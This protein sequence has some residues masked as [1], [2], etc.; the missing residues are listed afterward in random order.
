MSKHIG[1][2]CQVYWKDDDEWYE[3]VVDEF[4]PD[5]GWHVQY[6]DGDDEWIANIDDGSLIRFDKV[7]ERNLDNTGN[8]LQSDNKEEELM[9]VE[10]KNDEEELLQDDE[11]GFEGKVDPELDVDKI[12]EGEDTLDDTMFQLPKNNTDEVLNDGEDDDEDAL[13]EEIGGE[14]FSNIPQ[15]QQLN[16]S[17]DIPRSTEEVKNSELYDDVNDIDLPNTTFDLPDRGIILM[18]TITSATNMPRQAENETDGRVFFRVLYVDGGS[19][20][21]MF[22]CKT[23]IFSSKQ[24]DDLSFPEWDNG[25]F[26]FEMV[27][28]DPSSKGNVDQLSTASSLRKVRGK[29]EPKVPKP[30]SFRVHGEILV[31]LYR[32]RAQGGSEFVGQAVFD[33]EDL[34]KSGTTHHSNAVGTQVRSTNGSFPVITRIGEVAGGGLCH[35]DVQLELAWKADGVDTDILMDKAGEEIIR[36][37]PLPIKGRTP[38]VPEGQQPSSQKKKP[39][40]LNAKRQILESHRIN[41]ENLMLAKRIKAHNIK[42]ANKH[43]SVAKAEDVYNKPPPDAGSQPKDAVEAAALQFSKK[44]NRMERQEL[45]AIY[46]DLKKDVF[47]REQEKKQTLANLSRLKL[48]TKKYGLAN[49]RMK[50]KIDSASAQQTVQ[51]SFSQVAESKNTEEEE[52][53]AVLKDKILSAAEEKESMRELR[54]IDETYINSVSDPEFREHLIEFSALQDARRALVNRADTA[55][56]QCATHQASL[57]DS[58]QREMV[59]RQRLG[60]AFS[61]LGNKYAGSADD[62]NRKSLT[63]QQKAMED[64]LQ[65]I[66]RVRNVQLE[67]ARTEAAYESGVHLGTLNDT[68]SELQGVEQKL[69][70]LIKKTE[71][72]LTDARTEKSITQEKLDMLSKERISSKLRDNL[73]MMNQILLD[74]CRHQ[75]IR[76][77]DSNADAIELES[78]RMTLKR[79]QSEAQ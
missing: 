76:L 28:P 14:E 47:N 26:R 3:G 39:K 29:I 45:L 40:T 21:T 66:E 44:I 73:G 36:L 31:A 65:S 67:L 18:G 19:K 61:K 30:E 17:N 64:D 71:I 72:E 63:K 23:P 79:Q 59:A 56:R 74:L 2:T 4:H 53:D 52:I 69:K 77:A 58:K 48:H 10:S 43:T 57:E 5:Q 37:R 70:S 68:M 75:K 11:M 1:S 27:L 8:T 33:L 50:K 20:S 38:G 60:S 49:D 22:R 12:F 54:D 51:S 6:F 34:A 9:I 15:A 7:A 55:R 35:V 62:K 42:G 32:T 41:K 78:L 46:N 16:F 25:S 24:A 13:L